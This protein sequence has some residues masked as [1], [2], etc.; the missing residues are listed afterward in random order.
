VAGLRLREEE[1]VI[2]AFIAVA[3]V[4]SL[5]MEY[6]TRK[7]PFVH[8]LKKEPWGQSSFI[9]RD[10]ATAFA[11]PDRSNQLAVGA[12]VCDACVSANDQRRRAI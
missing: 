4:K 7:V 2:S 9:V 3:N 12:I 11:S 6:E 8:W 5:F 10:P 1:Q